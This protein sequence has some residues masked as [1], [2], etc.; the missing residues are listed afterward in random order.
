MCPPLRAVEIDNN[1]CAIIA[2]T[3][4]V[5]FSS[6][7]AKASS[8]LRKNLVHANRGLVQTELAV[9]APA[10]SCPLSSPRRIKYTMSMN[11]EVIGL[12]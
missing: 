9:P 12:G 5:H 3:C 2:S 4:D 11:R 6:E 8:A 1:N 7:L 10:H